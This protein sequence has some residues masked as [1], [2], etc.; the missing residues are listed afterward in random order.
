[1]GTFEDAFNAKKKELGEF[2]KPVVS[3]QQKK[4]MV[5]KPKQRQGTTVINVNVGPEYGQ[6]YTRP[7]RVPRKIQRKMPMT[8]KQEYIVSKKEL[9]AG[10]QIAR[11][12]AKA[13]ASGAKKVYSFLKKQKNKKP[14]G[15]ETW[16][17][18]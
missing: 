3:E 7:M 15:K 8:K 1:M 4:Q 18:K 11:Q 14:Y 16:L 17:K 2:D 13:T 12:G 9:D 10:V 5:Q 6:G